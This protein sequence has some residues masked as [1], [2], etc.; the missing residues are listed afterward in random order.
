A[1]AGGAEFER[2]DPFTGE[3]ATVAAAAGRDDARAAVEAAGAAFDSWSQST[4]A[5]R[6]AVLTEAARLLDERAAEIAATMTAEVGATFG[7]GMFNCGLG[8][9]VLRA[10][11]AQ[12]YAMNGETIPSDV[13]G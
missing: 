7:W 8:A 3:I 6:S 9:G 10:A 2:R 4:P 11:A 13:P 5:E 12:A 1:A